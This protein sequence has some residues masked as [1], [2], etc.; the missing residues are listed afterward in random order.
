MKLSNIIGHTKTV[1]KHKWIVFK[2]CCKVGIPWRGL[3]H[4]LSKF[5][6]TEFWESAKYY[7]GG[8]YSPIEKAKKENQYSNVWFHHKGRNKHHIEY[9]LDLNSKQKS[10]VMPFKYA[11]EMVCDNLAAGIVYK[12]KNWTKSEQYDYWMKKRQQVLV[13]PKI[14]NFLTEFYTQVKEKG[15]KEALTRENVKKIYNKY[16]VEDKNNYVYEIKGEWRKE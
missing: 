7:A 5:S 15:I 3:V 8:K 6:P 2:L 16:C 1:L 13:N 12:G 10:F 9:W 14:D 4:D 11:L